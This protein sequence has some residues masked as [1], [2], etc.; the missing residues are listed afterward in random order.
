M[1]DALYPLLGAAI[2]AVIGFA[3]LMK[4]GSKFGWLVVAGACV[5]AWFILQPAITAARRSSAGQQGS[6]YYNVNKK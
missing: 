3:I 2:V 1:G 4:G 5:W 6:S